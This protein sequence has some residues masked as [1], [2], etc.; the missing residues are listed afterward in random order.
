MNKTLKQL[1][2]FIIKVLCQD[3]M[4]SSSLMA[5]QI[6][7]LMVA[8]KCTSGAGEAEMEFGIPAS[9]TKAW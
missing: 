4:I 9:S 5:S 1:K 6:R 7:G 3:G 2:Q 8:A